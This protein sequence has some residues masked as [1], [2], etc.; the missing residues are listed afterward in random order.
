[1]ARKRVFS[2]AVALLSCWASAAAAQAGSPA[3]P[4]NAQGAAVSVSVGYLER[5]L[6]GGNE[7]ASSF[8]TRLGGAFGVSDELSLYGYAGVS[9]VKFRQADFD[10]SRG[11]DLGLGARYALLSFPQSRTKLVLDLQAGML[12]V[13]DDGHTV[14]EEEYHAATYVVKELAA[15][16]GAG[17][18]HPYGGFR[19]S[20]AKYRGADVGG[21]RLE[22]L[23]GAFLGADYFLTP[24]VYFSGA[25]HLFDES[26]LTVSAGYRF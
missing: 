12:R 15:S 24:N 9:D 8:M 26:S 23:V 7:R 17:A 10:G 13:T 22:T 20:F 16:G 21:R 19:A 1:M 18:L 11:A 6:R 25:V 3:A 14:R 4:L 5:D 2:L